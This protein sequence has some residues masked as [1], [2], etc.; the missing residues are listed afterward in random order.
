MTRVCTVTDCEREDIQARGMCR[1]HYFRW[2]RTGSTAARHANRPQRGICVVEGCEN[3]DEGPHGLCPMHKTRERRHGNTETVLTPRFRRG[4][5]SHHW[6]GDGA[7]YTAMHLRVRK[8]R[9]RAAEHLCIDCRRPAAQ[10][11]YDRADPD[12]RQSAEGPYSVRIEHYEPR[13][14]PCHKRF[15]LEATRATA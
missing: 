5:E 9:G 8:A 10:W 11:S 3:R 2:Y 1:M 4:A 13:C 14:V 12:Q 7:T 15:D 6:T